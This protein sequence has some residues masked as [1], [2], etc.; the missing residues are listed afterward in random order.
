MKPALRRCNTEPEFSLTLKD[1][2]FNSRYNLC[3]HRGW[4]LADSRRRGIEG[5]RI[6]QDITGGCHDYH[7]TLSSSCHLLR[8][9]DA[10]SWGRLWFIFA[11]VLGITLDGIGTRYAQ[12]ELFACHLLACLWKEIPLPPWSGDV[13]CLKYG[14]ADQLLIC[15]YSAAL[16]PVKNRPGANKGLQTTFSFNANS[17]IG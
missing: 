13:C 7:R 14:Y 15:A 17:R 8:R 3:T 5:V 6:L 10:G 12:S 16:L 11:D 9:A 2:G 1:T 4:V